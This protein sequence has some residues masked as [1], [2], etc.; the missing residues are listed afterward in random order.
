MRRR[1][2]IYLFCGVDAIRMATHASAATRTTN[3]DQL[4]KAIAVCRAQATRHRNV[5]RPFAT[6]STGV[7]SS[8]YLFSAERVRRIKLLKRQA[9][10]NVSSI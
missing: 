3:T 10:E 9:G 4:Q 8:S 5:E 6:A 2:E 7:K 1:H